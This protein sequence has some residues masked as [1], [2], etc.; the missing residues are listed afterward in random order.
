M[1][2]A[3][4]APEA[5]DEGEVA[6]DFLAVVGIAHTARGETHSG[7]SA[8]L[9]E[10]ERPRPERHDEE[11]APTPARIERDQECQDPEPHGERRHAQE[12]TPAPAARPDVRH[13]RGRAHLAAESRGIN[14]PG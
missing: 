7:V 4:L 11:G 13:S 9:Q 14:F 3:R 5:G 8:G 2:L 6:D 10:S 12:E 1:D